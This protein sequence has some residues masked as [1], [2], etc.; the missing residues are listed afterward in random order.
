MAEHRQMS[1]LVEDFK[2]TVLPPLKSGISAFNGLIS[3]LLTTNTDIVTKEMDSFRTLRSIIEEV[4]K[5]MSQ[6]EEAANTRLRQ[7]DKLTENLTARKGDLERRQSEKS[8]RLQD[9]KLKLQSNR[10]ILEIR[11]KSLNKARNYKREAQWKLQDLQNKK[12]EA[13]NTRNIGIGLAFIPIVGWIAG[14]I[15]I[16]VGQEDLDQA[17]WAA[18]Q[19]DQEVN[20]FQS[21]INT[22]SWQL[23]ENEKQISQVRVEMSQ[24]SADV[25]RIQQDLK[26][27]KNQRTT[28]ANFQS[29]MRNAVNLLGRLTG[30]ASVAEVQTRA[31]VLL[32]PVISA[33]ENVIELAGHITQQSLLCDRNLRALI[34]TLQ[35]NHHK[36]RAIE[37]DKDAD[38]DNDFY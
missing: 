15:M 31:F 16:G 1:Q 25:E 24:V 30:T 33:L 10:A 3:T 11:T 6:S 5:Y 9:L 8:Q 7:V 26:T 19:A 34:F 20:A 38:Q 37:A 29:K 22:I 4:K 36:L 32:G 21:H 35:Q 18:E 17:S 27:V 14:G 28:I 2:S 12:K 13:E 23:S